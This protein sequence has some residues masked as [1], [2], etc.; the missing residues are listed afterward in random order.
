MPST[1]AEFPDDVVALRAM[2]AAQAAEIAAQAAD[3]ATH[4]ARLIE[5]LA[6]R[7]AEHAELVAARAGLIEQRYEIEALRARL[8][9]ALRVAFGR[10]SEKLRE[11]VEQLELTL[12]DIDELLAETAPD[13][14]A[15]SVADATTPEA[16]SKPARKPLPEALPRE[17]IEHAAPGSCPSCGGHLRPLGEDVTEI[18]EYVPGAF[19]VIRHVRPKSSCR[20][21]E[22]IAQAPAPSLPVARGRAGPGL[23][24]H[25]LVAKYADHLPLHRQA[26]IYARAEI[27]LSRSTLADMV[28]QMVRLLRPLVDA[29]GRHVMAGERVHADDTV[30]PVLEPGLGRTR[31]A[32]LWTYVRDDRPFAG[33]APP[34]VLYRYSGD[35][36]GEHPR[37][38]LQSFRGIL[39]ADGYAGFAGLYAGEVIEAACMAHVR[40]KFWDAHEH[41]KAPVAHEALQ[42]IAALYRI[43]DTIRG[44]PAEQRLRVRLEHTAPL[45]AE[46]CA[47]LEAML[48]RLPG[49]SDT[50]K[51]IRYTLPRWQALTLMLRDGRACID[52]S[53]AE[54]AI[55]PITLGRRNWTFAGS[56][57]GGERAAA[58]YSLIETAKLNGLDP[59]DYLR[60]VIAC[61]ADHP[62][63]RVAELLPWNLPDAR[64]RLDQRRAA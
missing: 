45:M 20:A 2:L 3:I 5:A 4:K 30:V 18:L 15:P 8:A 13:A 42:R 16:T 6:A 37:A 55:R 21:C 29:L 11:R 33:P 12:A 60:R 62:V 17:V 40:R 44:R 56:D 57:A 10:S 27:D 23:L 22:T 53:A 48:P 36:K 43:E 24:A 47:W 58:I 32:R 31:T 14:A 26:E 61:I 35:R 59:E 49:R 38:H 64:P 54:R 51:T 19:R 9:R 34:A 25:V 50:A 1:S 41:T 39:Q 63:N 28:G 7:D 52:N 46:L